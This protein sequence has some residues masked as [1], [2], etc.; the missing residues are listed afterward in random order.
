MLFVLSVA[1]LLMACGAASNGVTSHLTK[2]I[3]KAAGNSAIR[4]DGQ[5]DGTGWTINSPIPEPTGVA[6]G[7]T[8]ASA[9]GSRIY[10]IGGITGAM[11]PT[12][13]VRAYSPADD[14]WSDAADIP[15][16]TGIR[17]FGATVELNGFIYVFGGVD[18]TG[19]LDTTWIYDEAKD[20]WSRGATMPGPRFGS[21]V[22][23]DG[24]SIWVG[25]GKQSLSIA[26]GSLNMWRYDT[27]SDSWPQ[28]QAQG[29]GIFMG[30]SR[31]A[32]LP[33]GSIH[34]LGGDFDGNAHCLVNFRGR[35]GDCRPQIPFGVTD[36]AIVTDGTRI[37][38]AGGGGPAP[39]APGRTQIFNTVTRTWSLGPAMPSGVD[40]TSGAI[41]NGMLYV[42]G[43]YD[44][45]TP[46]SINY[47][48]PLSSLGSQE[49]VSAGSWNHNAIRIDN[50]ELTG[51]RRLDQSRWRTNW[52]I[53]E[54]LGCAQGATLASKDGSLIYHLGGWVAGGY[55]LSNRLRVYSPADDIGDASALRSP[56]WDAANIPLSRGI[57]S[58]GSAVELN[59]FLYIFGGF[60][61]SES[62]GGEVLKTTWIYDEANDSWSR[63]A[64]MPDYSFGSAVATDGA[65]VW[66]IGGFGPGHTVWRY[67]PKVDAYTTGFT[68]MPID[69]GRIHGVWLPDGTVHV[70]G[71]FDSFINHHLVYDTIANAWSSAPSIPLVVIDPAAVTD[72]K[73]IYLAGSP[74]GPSPLGPGHTQIF[75]PATSTWSEGPQMPGPYGIDNTSGAIGN[76]VFYVMG[77]NVGGGSLVSDSYS[78]PV[79]ELSASSR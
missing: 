36:A 49:T 28:P 1:G 48:L 67:D 32:M 59:G 66:V 38:V 2:A 34:Y 27:S 77:G 31:G 42:M 35:Y 44:G 10:H 16:G 53:P 40:N 57:R 71:G 62:S 52:P 70:F 54:V 23:V 64:D 63:G 14:T 61:G 60:S 51:E 46:V 78:I 9:D 76:G 8:V 4:I 5:R 43:G 15:V 41:A 75:D 68:D 7:A 73:L 6:Q 79:S 25:G 12:K 30:R 11:T 19:V 20:A 72:G 33:D 24:S 3:A 55:Y 29:L 37:Y 69:L 18:E 26:H 21:L 47:S 50:H 13:K 56:W 17:T 58:F 74:Y 39:R 22:V 65:V 45:S